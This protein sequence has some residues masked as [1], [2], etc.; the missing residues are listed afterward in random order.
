[1]TIQI[2]N[3]RGDDNLLFLLLTGNSISNLTGL[4]AN[5]WTELSNI[6][7]SAGGTKEISM[8]VIDGGR[9]YV[10]YAPLPDPGKEPD[11]E[12]LQYYG[13]IEFTKKPGENTFVNLS[14]VDIVGLPLAIA[15]TQPGV[16]ETWTLG[17]KTS[18]ADIVAEMKTVIKASDTDAIK[19]AQSGQTKIVA[20]NIKPDSYVGNFDGY[21]NQLA[22][23]KAPLTI[24]SDAPVENDTSTIKVFTGSFL[25]ATADSDAVIKL[26][27]AQNDV[28]E[29]PKSCFT[30]EII[31]KCDAI[32][33]NDA[34][35]M[36]RYKTAGDTQF[37][38]VKPN[39]NKDAAGQAD[40]PK[41]E[42]IIT[43]SVFRNLCIGMNEGYFAS[44]GMNYSANFSFLS[45]FP[46]DNA[47][48]P[49]GNA[50][51]RIINKHSNS[52]GFPYADSNLKVLVQS[53]P[54]K[55]I[56]L[57]ILK[58]DETGG[59]GSALEENKPNF[60]DF[61]FAIGA[62]SNLG[63]I[64][65]G[66]CRYL[67]TKDNAYGGFFPTLETWTKMSFN[68]ETNQDR[69]IWIKTFPDNKVVIDPSSNFLQN[70]NRSGLKWDQ[71]TTKRWDWGANISWD[72]NSTSP[73]QPDQTPSA[74]T[75]QIAGTIVEAPKAP[76]QQNNTSASKKGLLARLL[77]FLGVPQ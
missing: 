70:N 18:V 10:G 56:T 41:E 48:K 31:F 6:P 3:Q 75:G 67:P 55:L 62:N 21:L 33:A 35:Q 57:T 30:S 74:G 39:R 23:A 43:N 58:D 25:P 36:L 26:T 63:T 14:N 59:F 4:S 47:G 54:D 77:R 15:G 40:G 29:V 42:C 53:D 52:Y 5:T 19:T 9:L 7:V 13:W 17:Y 71:A 68:T 69:F 49:V 76:D 38:Q 60:N 46:N 1:M 24:F 16:T 2:V 73:A 66:N 20:P 32:K 34:S 12:G 8:D 22:N 64:T 45:P 37:R 51:A 28:L 50:Y 27:S 72:V 11:P 44:Q 61:E 65:I